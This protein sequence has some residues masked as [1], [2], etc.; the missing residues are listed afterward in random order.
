V[1]RLVAS[2]FLLGGVTGVVAATKPVKLRRSR[3]GWRAGE[4]TAVDGDDRAGDERGFGRTEPNGEPGHFF[5]GSDTFDGD[6][7]AGLP[8][9]FLVEALRADRPSRRA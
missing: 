8:A 1:R 4:A 7:L 9:Q 2:L 6:R 5:G 3:E